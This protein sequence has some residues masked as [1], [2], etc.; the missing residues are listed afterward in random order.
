MPTRL[1]PNYGPGSYASPTTE[2][3]PK[4]N[5][6]PV[7]GE[8]VKTETL[9]SPPPTPYTV[10]PPEGGIPP[11]WGFTP[12]DPK[13]AATLGIGTDIVQ[14]RE[15]D[16]T[17]YR[18]TMRGYTA[19]ELL[20]NDEVA[21][22]VYNIAV[23]RGINPD[24]GWLTRIAGPGNYDPS[25]PYS[26]SIRKV[27]KG[28]YKPEDVSF[29][30]GNGWY[31]NWDDTFTSPEGLT[32]S[33]EQYDQIAA[34]QQKYND[35][36]Y[37]W[38]Q[39]TMSL[40][41]PTIEPGGVGSIAPQGTSQEDAI[42]K[43]Q[44][45]FDQALTI[46]FSKDSVGLDLDL[47]K[48]L[49]GV[50]VAPSTMSD[51]EA[52]S[53]GLMTRTD[54]I[55]AIQAKSQEI[56][57]LV[58]LQY[59]DIDVQATYKAATDDPEGFIDNLRK[60][61]RTKHTDQMLKLI[62]GDLADENFMRMIY[63]QV[64]IDSQD[65][66]VT[67]AV[68]YGA[69]WDRDKY[70]DPA[71]AKKAY[72]KYLEYMD[73][74]LINNKVARSAA[75]G[76]FSL[77]ESMASGLRWAGENGIAKQLYVGGKLYDTKT[78][79]QDMKEFASLGDGLSVPDFDPDH[80]SF[81]D[82]YTGLFEAVPSSVAMLV[83]AVA[84]STVAG[85]GAAALGLGSLATAIITTVAGGS[86]SRLLESSQ[87]ALGVYD[88]VL[89]KT[90][91]PIQAK[92]ASGKVF[93]FNE[94]ITG[95]DILQFGAAFVKGGKII[96]VFKGASGKGFIKA[97]TSPAGRITFVALTESGEEVYQQ[98][99]SEWAQTGK[100]TW[101]ADKIEVAIIG[102]IMGGAMGGGG[103]MYQSIQDRYVQSLPP[104]LK[105]Q[106]DTAKAQ[107]ASETEA[108]EVVASTPEGKK[109]ADVLAATVKVEMTEDA[110]QPKDPAQQAIKETVIAAQKKAADLD[111]I[112]AARVE[113]AV[114]RYPD[115][116]NRAV[117][118]LQETGLSPQTIRDL[119]EYQYSIYEGDTFD[120][121]TRITQFVNA[122]LDTN[123]EYSGTITRESL[124][125]YLIKELATEQGLDAE[126]V[127]SSA[128]GLTEVGQRQLL[129]QMK[130]LAD[131]VYNKMNELIT[132]YPIVYNENDEIIEVEPK[133]LALPS[134]AV[135]ETVIA[136][137]KKAADLDGIVAARIQPGSGEAFTRAAAQGQMSRIEYNMLYGDINPPDL[138]Y[139]NF[140]RE[141]SVLLKDYDNYGRSN[142]N[143]IIE[144]SIHAFDSGLISH[145][146]LLDYVDT[147]Y[148]TNDNIT[149]EDV[150]QYFRG[151][152]KPSI[153]KTDIVEKKLTPEEIDALLADYAAKP[154]PKVEP[155]V[156]EPWMM[157]REEYSQTMNSLAESLPK[158][159]NYSTYRVDQT[160][161]TLKKR[162]SEAN[163]S[164]YDAKTEG[165]TKKAKADI[166]KATDA[167]SE[168]NT[169]R[170]DILKNR[171]IVAE[172]YNKSIQEWLDKN[173]EYIK[174]G[175]IKLSDNP[176][177]KELNGVLFDS[178]NHKKYVQQALASGKPVPTSVMAE[179]PE[180]ANQP[181]M[182]P[183]IIK[184]EER[185][186][187][188]RYLTNPNNS[189]EA[190]EKYTKQLTG[191]KEVVITIDRPLTQKELDYFVN[192]IKSK[193]PTTIHGL[194]QGPFGLSTFVT[195]KPQP[196]GT[197]KIFFDMNL[198]TKKAAEQ[199][200]NIDFNAELVSVLHK[201]E[202]PELVVA[203]K[204]GIETAQPLPEVAQPTPYGNVEFTTITLYG[205]KTIK[206]KRYLLPGYNGPPL[207]VKQT[208]S[209]KGMPQEKTYWVY[210][211]ETGKLVD[212]SHG[213]S[214]LNDTLKLAVKE[215]RNHIE[216]YRV[217]PPSP[218]TEP[219]PTPVAGTLEAGVAV[220]MFG[221]E[222]RFTPTGRGKVTQISMDDQLKLVKSF[223]QAQPKNDVRIAEIEKLL[224]VKGRLPKE[225]N[226]TKGVLQL[227]LARLVAQ[228]E[229]AADGTPE[230]IAVSKHE[231]EQ[232]LQARSAP[233]HGGT[234][235][236]DRWRNYDLA[237]LNEIWKV[238]DKAS[239]EAVTPTTMANEGVGT[240]KASLFFG[241][242]PKDRIIKQSAEVIKQDL[243]N[244]LKRLAYKLPGIKQILEAERPGLKMTGENEKLL[245]ANI[246]ESAAKGDVLAMFRPGRQETVN[247]LVKEF[248]A[249]AVNEG[250]TLDIGLD[251]D[252]YYN[253]TKE[254]KSLLAD[255]SATD[256]QFLSYAVDGYDAEIGKYTIPRGKP[257]P[258]SPIFGTLLDIMQHEGVFLPNVN[259][260]VK[261]K[262]LPPKNISQAVASGRSK[263]RYYD[264]AS[265]RMA[266][267][268]NFH[269]V[270]DVQ[271]LLE[272]MD[273]AKANA[274]AGQTFREAVGGKTRLEVMA[275]THPELANKIDTLN[276]RLSRF[277]GYRKILQDDINQAVAGLLNSPVED[278][279]AVQD[280]LDVRLEPGRYVA[281]KMA[282]A[283][284]TD[285][286][287]DLTQIQSELTDLRASMK[288]ANPQ[289][290]VFVQDGI[291]RYFKE[292]QAAILKEMRMGSNGVY[293]KLINVMEMWRGTA[294]SG[295]LS[296]IVGVQTPLGALFD[297]GGSLWRFGGAVGKAIQEG[298][299]VRSFSID[300]L[301]RDIGLDPQKWARFFSLLGRPPAG[302]PTEY[303]GG[304]LKYIPGF[305]KF[306]EGTYIAVT[307]QQK[308]MWESLT[309]VAMKHGASQLEAEVAAIQKVTEVFPMLN[310]KELGQ[311]PAKSIAIR[312]AFTSI[313]F[314]R[315]PANMIE[316]TINGYFKIVTLQKLTPQEHLAVRMLTQ[317]TATTLAVSVLS[318]VLDAERR[319]D[320]VKK[321]M[322]DAINPDPNNGKFM[323]I[324][325]NEHVR[326]PIGGPYRAI[327]RAIY[328]QKLDGVPIPI[329]FV[330]LWQYFANRINPMF[331][332]QIDLL[333][334]KDYYNQPILTGEGIERILRWLEYQAESFVPL[335]I[336]AVAED[337]RTGK[338][339][340]IVEDMIAQFSG[341]NAVEMN[342]QADTT[343]DILNELG[344][345][346][347][348]DP[349]KSKFSSVPDKYYMTSD[350]YSD[351]KSKLTYVNPEDLTEKNGYD[352]AAI[353]AYQTAQL[354]KT[355][356]DFLSG[357]VLKSLDPKDVV[358]WYNQWNERS[359]ITDPVKLAA[360]DKANPNIKS[361]N[362]TQYD[363]FIQYSKLTDSKSKEDFVAL[364]PEL[365]SS[366]KE[367]WL[368]SHPTE[369]AQLALWGQ[370]DVTSKSA[371]DKLVALAKSLDIPQSAVRYL[372]PDS[373]VSAYGD[374]LDAV[375]KYGE[376]SA[377]AKNIVFTN[378]PLQDWFNSKGKAL[379]SGNP[380]STAIK[381]KY[382]KEY[383]AYGALKDTASK[384]KYLA[385]NP[386]FRDQM[387]YAEGL[388]EK[389]ST[390]ALAW[391]WVGY[392]KT[393][394]G[395]ARITFR[396]QHPD[397]N[398]WYVA[399]KHAQ[400]LTTS[401]GS[402]SSGFTFK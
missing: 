70:S 16:W 63:G 27:A 35:D 341:F 265:D 296:P 186:I 147:F 89:D 215:I 85:A 334:N 327:F 217:Q 43:G 394:E 95:W 32:Y 346:K 249:E 235:T 277:K 328:P 73:S 158:L 391:L 278:M 42:A 254:Q 94:A 47:K 111:G 22:D 203:P 329:P 279:T 52:K 138:P 165:A 23:S 302:T 107:G 62:Y 205:P 271:A 170:T 206:A 45:T 318:A 338:A 2:T 128:S 30:I 3:R 209:P 305:E 289:D 216:L 330:G 348:P 224:N 150:I 36:L 61:G 263:T 385:T 99:V 202:Y 146:E 102:G 66:F 314:I 382:E 119:L 294:F 339:N 221:N 91:D 233:F 21:L 80:T 122:R 164:L 121:S 79:S 280:L 317:M 300:A 154:M 120:P 200:L 18:H 298:N 372:P 201:A 320:D 67:K 137:Q 124:T 192:V 331:K 100:V 112:V 178:L 151:K 116:Y 268:K 174:S 86:A 5:Y 322:L 261:G 384:D 303:A 181:L 139:A 288:I 15:P 8:P 188:E 309:K 123:V 347:P 351:V 223:E 161:A 324:I 284:L 83:A 34:D 163:N 106:Y 125:K 197:A 363:L 310:P 272:G 315:K 173:A 226:T 247:L 218:T 371:L 229:I 11:G 149:G 390:T 189:K 204:A 352:L 6:G 190:I 283:S 274:A 275:E 90:G 195:Q 237:Q 258:N 17:A 20:A 381:V 321:A 234:K 183:V 93:G 360:Y 187:A 48:F 105:T 299:I 1:K 156:K 286:Q 55:A 179:Y 241:E 262:K 98:V 370:A 228:K 400:P 285:I 118:T 259:E 276:K 250:A 184:A 243:P 103:V 398:A 180:L 269:P 307:R 148:R 238:Y 87:E 175:V 117:A 343:K 242:K 140:L 392:Q 198:A 252:G 297:L 336:G 166:Q 362:R 325:V 78:I 72:D 340:Q 355:T 397:F 266:N 182:T 194:R 374:W 219:I 316:D 176:D 127:F 319:G 13:A 142:N 28:D 378:K 7:V 270:I 41:D 244:V 153:K 402:T 214:T 210:A 393:P 335:T 110:W 59:P 232:E 159:D 287:N 333:R 130:D 332:T 337:V 38:A 56:D 304:L 191:E 152:S 246:S 345:V 131:T 354:E 369:N 193:L 357:T 113:P 75:S 82:I 386:T 33:R 155:T 358:A 240:P 51:E 84:V 236:A 253:L 207:A 40:N 199:G 49:P 256:D 282:G 57:D 349:L 9:P 365:N 172:Q 134:P 251:K 71:Y 353:N 37:K 54:A 301:A 196:D 350:A 81:E 344:Q 25:I 248:T 295:D 58:K 133:T 171:P 377:Q 230:F 46:L 53:K 257:N 109:I 97:V 213:I 326:I 19:E 401:S 212:D 281:K 50:D 379:P 64:P 239:P 225:L 29:G 308:L 126:G 177:F 231:I 290:Y 273:S 129:Q 222:S 115:L 14:G 76:V 373:A 311:S 267:D 387:Y 92:E 132:N 291:Y 26:E 108:I 157:T 88:A 255:L 208:T 69:P 292:E 375:S 367:S 68:K 383:A 44:I 380:E 342:K 145:A 4:P 361:I 356:T 389:N 10:P 104:E 388:E 359:K 31:Q 12:L 135:K 96:N 368:I 366:P 143:Q 167:L 395:S 211:I 313:S 74:P 227:E 293:D 376:S 185:P 60:Q 24:A 323:S 399:N 162:V 245:N 101:N 144:R 220:D 396:Q 141:L 160:I 65:D 364:H 169:V 168:A 260:P 312:S 114:K 136:A 264:Y 39:E 306:N 77:I